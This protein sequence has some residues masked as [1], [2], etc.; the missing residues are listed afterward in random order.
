MTNQTKILKQFDKK[1]EGICC[2][3]DNVVDF[4]KKVLQNQ[5]R[6]FIKEIDGMITIYKKEHQRQIDR[7]NITPFMG[8]KD[9]SFRRFKNKTNSK[10]ICSLN[11]K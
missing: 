2:H 1:F 3:K 4:I 5:D 8:N 10:I 7:K 9:K 6:E 11:K